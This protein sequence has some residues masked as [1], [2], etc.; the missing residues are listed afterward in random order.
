MTRDI[1]AIVRAMTLEEKAS[2]CSGL[3]WWHTKPV[4]RL[5]VPSIMM[6]DG[7]YGLRRQREKGETEGL[8]ASVPATCFPT[9]AGLA[10]SWDREL[11]WIVGAAIAEEALAQGVSIVL[12]PSVNIKRSPLCG[13]NFEYLSEDPFL[14]GEMAS[15][16]IAGLQG[17]G[18]GASLKHFAANNQEKRRML[19]DAVVDERTLREI[20]LRAFETAV[21][22]SRPWTI[23]GAYNRLNGAYCCEN[24]WLLTDVLKREWDHEG[25]VVTDW[26]GNHD[27][28]AG[29]AA[30]QELEM[31]SSGGATDAQIVRAVTSGALAESVLD[32]AVRRILRVVFMGADNTRPG[33]TFDPDV[34][35]ALARKV[36][37]DCIVLLKNEGSALPL[38]RSGRI[39]FIGQFA[40]AP[41]FEGG[42]SSKVTPTRLDNTYEEARR[43]VGADAEIRF[44]PGYPLEGVKSDPVLTGEAAAAA[45]WAHVAVV[46]AGLPDAFESEGFDRTGLQ[47]PQ[48]HTELIDAV[49]AV[50]KNVVVVLSNGSPVEMPWAGKVKSIVEGYL[51]GQAAGGAMADVLFGVVD[52]SAKLAETFPVKLEDNPSFINFPGDRKRV[53]YR[54]GIFVGYRHYDG[55]GIEPLFPF[56]HGLSYTRFA[57]SD[58][59]LDR[60]ALLDTEGVTVTVKVR[61]TGPVA[62][63]E[64]V[65]LYVSD[66][67][68]SV[69]RP[70]KE[71]AG[72]QK[73]A[74]GPGEERTVSFAL[75]ARAFR[76]W[77][78]DLHDW[79]VESGEFHILVGASSR[80]IRQ[81][82]SVT[83]A[84]TKPPRIVY[85]QNTPFGELRE[86]PIGGRF[87]AA[88]EAPF[89][90]QFGDF[91]P[92]S[93]EAL[94][95]QALTS[96][97][98]IRNLVSLGKGAGIATP[99]LLRDLVEALNGGP[100]SE[101][102][103]Q[104]IG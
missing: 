16:W 19:V 68:S 72:F 79:R 2:L 66:T 41:R 74:L 17:R 78:S 61:N 6:S 24:R 59:R 60:A 45:A 35:H 90:S 104:L 37:G 84:S 46:F 87:L 101:R 47:L 97:L 56:G 26:G 102:L 81:R 36:A 82:A 9:G 98:P 91:K 15:G 25:I 103:R 33:A 57:Y 53:E 4:E 86:N 100:V 64:I 95:M 42:G 93:P 50:Q 75:D 8:L 13:R 14:A 5:G 99:E 22:A 29:L 54:E 32:D 48:S 28:V 52:P 55:M 62:G 3:D 10:A 18:V 27:R 89:L 80:D 76:F 7:P 31:P 88:V 83:V 85:D 65:Q 38:P 1:E 30:G 96:E 34:H 77:D 12:G 70:P 21:R 51:G 63:K 71:L 40:R 69:I 94:M 67:A 11:A 39:A 92:G 73:V 49:C 43:L 58:I 20:Y 44:A 23:M